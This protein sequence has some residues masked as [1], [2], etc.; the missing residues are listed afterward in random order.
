MLFVEFRVYYLL[1]VPS[2]RWTCYYSSRR[3]VH[4][5][6]K[7]SEI[8]FVPKQL[9][10]ASLVSFFLAKIIFTATELC[11]LK[12]WE[13]KQGKGASTGCRVCDDTIPSRWGSHHSWCLMRNV[14]GRS[15]LP[16]FFFIHAQK[17]NWASSGRKSYSYRKRSLCSDREL[18]ITISISGIFCTSK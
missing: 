3:Y 4:M 10:I 5:T 12:P 15:R 16:R 1:S 6:R 7:K 11:Q 17:E 18:V 14:I 8:D 9:S 13:E 2:R